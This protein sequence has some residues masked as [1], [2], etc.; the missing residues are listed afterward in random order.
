[1]TYFQ[2]RDI[3]AL[4]R[5][6]RQ[7]ALDYW[8]AVEPINHGPQ[9]WMAGAGA[10]LH[11]ETDASRPL[12]R[13]LS[14]LLPQVEYRADRLGVA[15]RGQ[16]FPPAAVGGPVLPFNLLAHITDR[17]VGYRYV[18]ADE[19]LDAIDR[20]VG[21]AEFAKRC[22]LQRLLKPW[23]WL[24]DGPALIVAWPFL[25]MKKAG[26]PESFINSTGA[27]VAKVIMTALLW[28]AGIAWAA[29]QGV[30]S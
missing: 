24:V 30:F 1:M 2:L 26:V 3:E 6:Y 27:Q 12:R 19:V 13:E 9:G 14:T 4:F 25:V 15:V 11:R 16:S 23:C 21:A 8:A 10:P 17:W 7:I 22:A 28:L 5:K 29:V 20:C 18:E